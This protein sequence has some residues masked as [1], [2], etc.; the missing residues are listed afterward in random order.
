MEGTRRAVQNVKR[1]LGGERIQG[2]AG[3]RDYI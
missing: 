2:V 3:R 1:M